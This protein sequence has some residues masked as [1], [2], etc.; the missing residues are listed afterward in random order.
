MTNPSRRGREESARLSTPAARWPGRLV[1]SST[2][3]DTSRRAGTSRRADS[4]SRRR[5]D[6]SSH[7]DTSG[8]AGSRNRCADSST[9]ANS[10]SRRADSSSRRAKQVQSAQTGAAGTQTA[11]GGQPVTAARTAT[12]AQTADA[13]L[14]ESSTLPEKSAPA[15]PGTS[16]GKRQ[17][18]RAGQLSGICWYSRSPPTTAARRQARTPR[19][20][21]TNGCTARVAGGRHRREPGDAAQA[22]TSDQQATPVQ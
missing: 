15:D 14:A 10:N 16:T 21:Q 7:A 1:D 17:Q 11:A 20:A 6:S 12:A 19:L 8:H 2:R 9:R 18:S 5:A 22:L 4:S 13:P 3:T